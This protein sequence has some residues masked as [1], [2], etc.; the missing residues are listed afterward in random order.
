MK[1][2]FLLFFCCITAMLLL[3]SC[4]KAE[5]PPE[6]QIESAFASAAE[7]DS[8]ELE[9]QLT[10]DFEHISEHET[11]THR[12]PLTVLL[13]GQDLHTD[14]PKV[15]MT[16]TLQIGTEATS[17]SAYREGNRMYVPEPDFP[18]SNLESPC[19]F[20][21]NENVYLEGIYDHSEPFFSLLTDLP[22]ELYDGCHL[23]KSKGG[24]KSTSLQIT[25]TQFETLF[26]AF[27]REF[28]I[29]NDV[30]SH[31]DVLA[32]RPATLS[33]TLKGDELSVYRLDFAF[34]AT[35]SPITPSGVA[36]TDNCAV[37]YEVRIL[38]TGGVTVTPPE[39]YLTF[40]EYD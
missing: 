38:K 15:E 16:Y 32:Y 27:A 1:R 37:S 25:E 22:T 20:P 30:I 39:G 5:G 24:T 23:E 9:I 7:L 14:T 3:V 29:R 6:E 13:K 10:L 21:I 18:G 2:G 36:Y 35:Y 33:V 26:G 12:L 8:C 4:G 34:E 17:F 31:R 19:S 28:G 11:Y 40:P